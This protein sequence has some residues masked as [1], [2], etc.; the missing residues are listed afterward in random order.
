MLILN[1]DIDFPIIQG[2]KAVS[3]LS[4]K[5]VKTPFLRTG[6]ASRFLFLNLRSGHR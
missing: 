5:P 2:L 1:Q 6:N 3:G 4:R